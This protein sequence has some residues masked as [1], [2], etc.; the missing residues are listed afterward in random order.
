MGFFNRLFGNQEKNIALISLQRDLDLINES[1]EIIESTV[2][3]DTFF[4]RYDFYMEK[5]AVM[6]E[7][8]RNGVAGIK[9]SGESII[10]KYEKMTSSKQKIECIIVFIDRMWAD[11]C[12]KAKGLKTDKG[13]QNRYQKFYDRLQQYEYRMPQE[14]IQHYQALFQQGI[15]NSSSVFSPVAEHKSVIQTSPPSKHEIDLSQWYISVS[16]G[17]SSSQNYLKAV[18]LA[19][20]AP[21]YHEQVDG[22]HILHQAF[23]SSNPKDFLSF[24][25]LY[26][27]VSGW[28]SSFAMIN[29]EIIDRKIIGQL[30]YCYGDKCRSNKNDFCFGASFATENPF[31][32]HRIQISAYNNPW[33][34]YYERNGRKYVLNKAAIM[35]RIDATG[36]VYQYCPCFDRNRAIDA[37]NKLPSPI[38][39]RQF[40]KIKSDRII[41]LL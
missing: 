12:E 5:L 34:S 3:P 38:T 19:K 16:F 24:I 27:L 14:C 39:A 2:N 23:Y 13:R 8:E 28:K 4:S 1:A 31:G 6:A 33:W 10:E 11:T 17:K 7:K 21:Q 20:S 26:E 30:N 36:K 15:Q 25:M 22:G 41:K 18:T 9:F 35:Q 32:C 29:G 37:L 40:E